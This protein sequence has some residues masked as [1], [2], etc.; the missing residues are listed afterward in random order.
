MAGNAGA[1]GAIL[2]LAADLVFSRDGVVLNPHYRTMHL[3]GSEYWTYLLPRRVGAAMAHE[4]TERCQPLSAQ[5]A[6]SIGLIDDVLPGPLPDFHE[7]VRVRPEA[8]TA[9][10]DYHDRLRRQTP[11]APVRRGIEDPWRLTATTSWRTCRRDFTNAAY[12]EA[13]RRFLS[14]SPRMQTSA[15]ET[16]AQ[17]SWCELTSIAIRRA[18]L[19][20]TPDRTTDFTTTRPSIALECYSEHI[21]PGPMD[22]V[23]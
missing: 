7:S 11:A 6:K 15:P 14:V 17:A 8:L 4:L 9:G 13:R 18:S 19:A 5:T 23:R 10:T 21:R 16:R 3:Y 1:G 20:F 12:H 2:A 22:A